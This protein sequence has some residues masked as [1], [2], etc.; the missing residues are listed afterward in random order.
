MID[1]HHSTQPASL[2]CWTPVRP[3]TPTPIRQPEHALDAATA[4]WD[5]PLRAYDINPRPHHALRISSE[6]TGDHDILE[7]ARWSGD[8]GWVMPTLR[9][10]LQKC[11]M[12]K[13]MPGAR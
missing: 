11:S 8:E 9:A 5:A 1:P 4:R 6:G 2:S 3:S 13:P 7:A 12:E 10:T